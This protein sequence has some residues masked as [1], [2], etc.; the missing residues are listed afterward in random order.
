MLRKEP[1]MKNRKIIYIAIAAVC[2]IAVVAA[3]YAQFF[4]KAE[5]R[6]NIIM[7]GQSQTGDN[8]GEKT[9]EQ[10]KSDFTKLFTN[11]L[12]SGNYDTSK[13]DKIDPNKDIVYTAYDI[14]EKTENYEVNVHL[15]VMNILSKVPIGFNNI[16]QTIFADKASEILSNKI[17]KKVLYQIN[18]VAYINGDILSLIIEGTLKQGD[19][20]QRVIVQTYNYNLA[21]GQKV[22][23]KD[24]LSRKNL[25]PNDVQNKINST[26][27]KEKKEEEVLSQSGYPV[28]NRDLNNKMYQIDNISTYFLGPNENLY[29][30]FAY[31]NQNYTSEMDIILYE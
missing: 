2:I 30:I 29:I 3:I 21:T 15:P 25:E 6:D 19:D 7:P 28:Y 22:E 4:V 10:I 5:D 11:V 27:Q 8:I 17:S 26:V 31:G 13:I 12:N 24:L 20:P 16:T 23:V 9:K 1:H 14:N 18:Y